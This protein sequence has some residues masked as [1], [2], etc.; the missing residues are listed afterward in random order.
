M[1]SVLT[2]GPTVAPSPPPD[3]DP[4]DGLQ[5]IVDAI[6]HGQVYELG[7][8]VFYADPGD[9]TVP[10]VIGDSAYGLVLRGQA[11]DD[12]FIGSPILIQTGRIG[13]ER[14]W[15]RAD[16]CDYG[17]KMEGQPTFRSRC[18]FD[19]IA[20]GA[21][22]KAAAQ[23]GLGPRDGLIM[24]GFGV[25]LAH[26]TTVAFNRR[27]GLVVDSTPGGSNQPNTTLKFDMCSF[28]QNGFGPAETEGIGIKLLGSCSIAEFNGGNSEGNKYGEA[29]CESMNNPRFRD[30]DFE[31]SEPMTNAVWFLQCNPGIIDGCNF[32]TVPGG[33]TRAIS[34]EQCEGFT[35]TGNR[36]AGWGHVGVVRISEGGFNNRYFGNVINGDLNYGFFEDY[37]R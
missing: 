14:L 33:A 37:S 5:P 9:P 34:V 7:A 32:L 13:L 12:T 21:S 28:V 20:I 29:Y 19:N 22:S 36:F 27:H 18:H 1:S 24:D 11:Q 6:T 4:A 3:L 8:G 31:T 23:A 10:L 15:V 35:I 17:V 16:G 30:F 25:F 2:W 26:K